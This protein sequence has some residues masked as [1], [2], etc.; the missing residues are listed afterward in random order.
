MVPQQGSHG[1]FVAEFRYFPRADSTLRTD[2]QKDFPDSRPGI[3]LPLFKDST[4]RAHC[5][6]VQDDCQVSGFHG[7]G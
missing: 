7:S 4:Q 5:V 3:P 6:F 1:T 2:N